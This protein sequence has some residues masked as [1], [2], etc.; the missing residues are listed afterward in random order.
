MPSTYELITATALRLPEQVALRF[1]PQADPD[2]PAFTWHY[3]ALHA[4]ITRFANWLR[5]KAWSLWP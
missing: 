2:S 4:Q 5:L 1:A 3:H